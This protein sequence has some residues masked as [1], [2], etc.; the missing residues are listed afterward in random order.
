MVTRERVLELF[1]YLPESGQFIRKTS[2]GGS[3]AGTVAGYPDRKGYVCLSID[4]KVYKAHRIAWL[5]AHLEMPSGHVDHINKVRSDNRVSN[6]R[7][8]SPAENLQN[9]ETASWRSG[10]GLIGVSWHKKTG[11]WCAKIQRD[12]VVKSLGYHATKEDAHA[13][14]LRAKADVHPFWQPSANDAR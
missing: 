12:G 1:D 3:I 9:R 11:A 8:A 13:A 5:V 7:L 2:R 10:S 6:L 14:Y 4:D